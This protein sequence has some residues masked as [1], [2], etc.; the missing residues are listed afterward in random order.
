MSPCCGV[1]PGPYRF[2]RRRRGGRYGLADRRMGRGLSKSQREKVYLIQHYET[3][4]GPVSGERDVQLGSSQ[5][6]DRALASGGR[7]RAGSRRRLLAQRP[8]LR[9]VR[10]RYPAR[11][12]RAPR[13]DALSRRRLEGVGGR[14][15]GAEKGQ[16]AGSGVASD[17]LRDARRTADLP[18]WI[19]YEQKPSPELLRRLYNDAAV[20]LATSWT[21]GWGLPGCEALLC[22]CALAATEVGGHLEYAHHNETALLSPPRDPAAL[23]RNVTELLRHPALRLQARRTGARVRAAFLVG[24]FSGAARA[25]SVKLSARLQFA[26]FAPAT[27]GLMTNFVK[28]LMIALVLGFGLAA[29]EPT[30]LR[31]PP[32]TQAKQ[33]KTLPRRPV[34]PLV[35]LSI[36][37]ATLLIMLPTRLRTPPK[38]RPTA[39]KLN[40]NVLKATSGWLF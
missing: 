24:A 33:L 32:R 29:C 38:T 1:R 25:V 22:G 40:L 12:A 2:A 39:T 5:S 31:M 18:A 11:G 7:A 14:V 30:K 16:G 34:T 4:S 17:A 27:L 37:L 28:Y 8:R 36:T 3:W 26:F 20:F 13:H 9:G 19:R 35:M 10:S 23:A 21:E 6:G 15:G